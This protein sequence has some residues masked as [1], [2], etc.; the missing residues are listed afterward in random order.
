MD[1]QKKLRTLPS[2]P[3]VYLM[4]DKTGRVIYAGKAA[5]IKKRVSSYFNRPQTSYKNE[6][7]ISQISDIQPIPTLSEHEAFLL[8]S[9]L[10]KKFNPRYNVSLKDDKSF[11]FI[12]IT[13]EDFPRIFMGRKK[14][15]EN[16][17]Y[18][19]P[20]TNVKLLRLALKSLRK[21]F[22]F[23]T[24]RA[25]PKKACLDFHLGLCL[26]P[27]IGKISRRDYRKNIGEFKLFL[28]KGSK[29]FIEDLEKRMK[30][31]AGARQFEQAIKLREKI[32][33]LGLVSR[34]TGLDDWSILGLEISPQRIE[35]FDISN[36]GGAEA[37]GA[38][39]T[40]VDNHPSKNDYRRFKIKMAGV[41]DDYQMLREVLHR[42]YTRLVK[43]G[44]VKPDL[45]VIDGGRGH[46]GAALN[47]LR[48]LNLD[49]PIIAIAKGEEL[50]YTVKNDAPL[51]LEKNNSVL[52]IVQHI[53]D[54]AHRFAIKYHKL[55]RKKKVFAA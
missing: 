24:C 5:N 53:R 29:Y 10:I 34:Q 46:L 39:V 52:Q 41:I 36:I 26:A 32:K 22:G 11:P 50:I 23:S 20:Y 37:V 16:V 43:E 7:L 8:E 14:P 49:I 18:L 40:F 42:R 44:Q 55:L 9:K 2:Q 17:D 45:I 47:Q 1:I 19:G 51:K 28:K 25:F 33:A 6:I 13:Q 21:V 38:M 27:C 30:A 35:A 15:S 12:K 4:K 48:L 3:G 54:E 31:L